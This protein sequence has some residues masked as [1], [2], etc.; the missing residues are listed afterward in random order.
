MLRVPFARPLF[1]LLT[2]LSIAAPALAADRLSNTPW[3]LNA[4]VPGSWLRGPSARLGY[5][6]T[7]DIDRALE[8]GGITMRGYDRVLRLSWTLADLDGDSIP[9]AD[10]VGR[11]LYLRK[12][13]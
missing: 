11:A 1:A 12:A 5:Q 2:A 7:K 6:T 4:H 9:S 3:R 8:R 10:H 13:M